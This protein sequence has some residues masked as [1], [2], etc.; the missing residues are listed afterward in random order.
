MIGYPPVS[1]WSG[2]KSH[3]L[4]VGRH[5]D[6]AG[7]RSLAGQLAAD[8]TLQRHLAPKMDADA[9]R[10]AAVTVHSWV[11]STWSASAVNQSSRG[12]SV[13]SSFDEVTGD[14][15]VARHGTRLDGVRRGITDREHDSGRQRLRGRVLRGVSV[16]RLPSAG[17]AST[18][19]G[20]R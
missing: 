20:P 18:P 2:R 16:A 10:S 12:P 13:I 7:D 4:P 15:E 3:R 17:A 19:R 6:R 9:G 5:L 1:G 11:V 8:G 14:R